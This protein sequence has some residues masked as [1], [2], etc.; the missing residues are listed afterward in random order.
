[1]TTNASAPER[2]GD[3]QRYPSVVGME[4]HR[5]EFKPEQAPRGAV[6]LVHGLGDHIGRY[7]EIGGMLSGRGL[8][9]A[10]VDLPGH[11]LSPGIRGHLRDWETVESIFRESVDLLRDRVGPDVPL[12]VIGHSMGGFA[13]LRFM[14]CE[15]DFFRFAWLSSPLIRPRQRRGPLINSLA[16]VVARVLP[17]LTL[18]TG[19]RPEMGRPV[20]R[21]EDRDPLSHHRV[22]S[23]F[24]VALLDMEE[25][26]HRD[27]GRFHTDLSLLVTHGDADVVCPAV[28]SREF[29]DS[30]GVS[31]K[32]YR[33]FPG[34]MHEP[35]RYEA[36]DKV[37]AA[38]GSWLDR[39]GYESREEDTDLRENA[40]KTSAAGRAV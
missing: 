30:V 29:Y 11:G 37:L 16:R 22:S 28:Y 6:L 40:E 3:S 7:R 25:E 10:G 34:V 18:D 14:Q 27:V 19:V 4:L 35:F 13:V 33:L 15:P 32:E 21:E 2:P 1:M 5:L 23:A 31:D 8:H 24:G 12:G 39:L 17:T 9:A 38:A 26:L 36:G 20:V